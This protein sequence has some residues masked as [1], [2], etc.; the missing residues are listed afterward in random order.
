MRNVLDDD[1]AIYSDPEDG[2]S[3]FQGQVSQ[4]DKELLMMHKGNLPKEKK[5]ND[6]SFMN[7][8]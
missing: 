5:E 8:N 4:T 3:D 7:K 6:E 1:N 2:D